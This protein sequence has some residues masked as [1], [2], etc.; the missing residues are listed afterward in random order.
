M[1]TNIRRTLAYE[2]PRQ[3]WKRIGQDEIAAFSQPVVILGDPG[4][5]KSVL[6]K[7]LG[8]LPGMNYVLAGV[9]SR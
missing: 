4:L 2:G 9:L 6:T 3:G 7:V 5:G 8:E 1:L